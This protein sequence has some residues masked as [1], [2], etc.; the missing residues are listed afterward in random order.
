MD[1]LS[2]TVSSE[3]LHP[4]NLTQLLLSAASRT[5]V[6][7]QVLMTYLDSTSTLLKFA[8]TPTGGGGG[9]RD[10]HLC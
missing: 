8:N 9:G 5:S 6:P 10:S 2:G 4:L 7:G 1:W 3:S